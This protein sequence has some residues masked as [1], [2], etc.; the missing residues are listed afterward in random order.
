MTI[1]SVRDGLETVQ[2]EG[3]IEMRGGESLSEEVVRE[4]FVRAM[5]EWASASGKLQVVLL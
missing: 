4:M 2:G 1:V 5:D 3:L